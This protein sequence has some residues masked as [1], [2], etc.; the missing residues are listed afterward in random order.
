M[1]DAFCLACQKMYRNVAD[2]VIAL[3]NLY[4]IA[5]RCPSCNEKIITFE[6]EEELF[7]YTF[8]FEDGEKY[9]IIALTS[10]GKKGELNMVKVVE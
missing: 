10:D 4:N 2:E 8:E 6:D 5:P 3:R 7:E 1:S 9:R